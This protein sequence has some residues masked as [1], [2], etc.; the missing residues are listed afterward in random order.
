MVGIAICLSRQSIRVNQQLSLAFH[1]SRDVKP[2][3]PAVGV[4]ALDCRT[5]ENSSKAAPVNST[6]PENEFGLDASVVT[7]EAGNCVYPA[8]RSPAD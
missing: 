8:Q 4:E 1:L 3:A 6:D 2:C 7:S 5:G